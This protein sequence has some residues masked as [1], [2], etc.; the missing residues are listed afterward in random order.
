MKFLQISILLLVS[1]VPQSVTGG[2]HDL[3]GNWE[4][5]DGSAKAIIY[6]CGANYCARNTWV[7]TGVREGVRN[8]ARTDNTNDHIV[9]TIRNE[10]E[11]FLSG[12]AYAPRYGVKLA[13]EAHILENGL[14]TR[15]CVMGGL[16]CKTWS[17]QRI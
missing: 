2:Y 4:R 9:I 7:R 15:G 3:V 1:L 12:E 13:I 6:R 10:S 8:G 14:R 5:V 16:I 17:W 11:G